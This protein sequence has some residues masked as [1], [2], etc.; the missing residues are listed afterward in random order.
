MRKGITTLASVA[1]L[2]MSANALAQEQHPLRLGFGMDLGVPSGITLGLVIHPT[3]D[4]LSIQTSLSFNGL[5]PGMRLGVKLD[6]VAHVLP[7]SVLGLLLEV[8]GGF[9]CYGTIPG[10]ASDMP[11]IGYEYVNLY[12]GVRFGKVNR[13]HWIFEVGPSHVNFNIMNFSNF[14]NSQFGLTTAAGST[15]TVNGWIPTFITGFEVV[16]P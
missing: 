16:W 2:C 5:A 15:P 10:H 1:L 14:M 6:P 12:G 13:F 4:W 3:V 8:Q 9:A 11:T 7:D